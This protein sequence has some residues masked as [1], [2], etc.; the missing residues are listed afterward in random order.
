MDKAVTLEQVLKLTKQLSLLDK[1]RLVEHVV[2]QIERE[3]KATQ[4]QSV[5]RQP[6]RGMWKGLAITEEEIDAARQ[7]MW[8]NFPREDI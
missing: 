5:P 4:S 3:V 1:I 8:S 2:P 6:L 7:E